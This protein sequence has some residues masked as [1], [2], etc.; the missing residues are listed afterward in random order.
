MLR[1]VCGDIVPV[2]TASHAGNGSS[3]TPRSVMMIPLDGVSRRQFSQLFE[4]T[5]GGVLR[6][7]KRGKPLQ[8]RHLWA[9]G[10]NSAPNMLRMVCGDSDC[11]EDL[12]LRHFRQNCFATLWAQEYTSI[13][14]PTA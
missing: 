4:K 2:W 7:L 11:A 1:L 10:F 13:S 6:Q 8:F 9:N 5:V 14:G 12:I 3:E